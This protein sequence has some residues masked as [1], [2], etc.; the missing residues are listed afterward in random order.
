V[1][2]FK[3][4][5]IQIHLNK[6]FDDVSDS[7]K[8]HIKKRVKKIMDKPLYFDCLGYIRESVCYDVDNILYY[9]ANKTAEIKTHIEFDIPQ[10]EE[11]R[12][13][14]EKVVNGIND[15]YY[16]MKEPLPLFHNPHSHA[17]DIDRLP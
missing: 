5:V 11:Q 7:M 15:K 8:F 13:K 2:I 6:E 4:K 14:T 17:T 12:A 16:F 3:E 1:E 10:L 9:Q